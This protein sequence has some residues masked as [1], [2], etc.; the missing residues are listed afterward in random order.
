MKIRLTRKAF[1][2][3]RFKVLLNN[4]QALIVNIF[5]AGLAVQ[6]KGR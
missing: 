1:G 2:V 5:G 4:E 3:K 6:K